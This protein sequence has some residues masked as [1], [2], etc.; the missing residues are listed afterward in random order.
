MMWPLKRKPKKCPLCGLPY[1]RATKI[2]E[3][4][5][6]GWVSG[7]GEN[8]PLL[9]HA[10]YE[11]GQMLCYEFEWQ[12]LYGKY[13][14]AAFDINLGLMPEQILVCGCSTK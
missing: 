5:T 7:D 2:E 4:C 14:E 8:V 3:W 12:D 9:G 11:G 1:K 10:T 13:G 6:G